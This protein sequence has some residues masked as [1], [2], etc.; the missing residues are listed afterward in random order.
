[1]KITKKGKNLMNSWESFEKLPKMEFSLLWVI[2]CVKYFL[3]FKNMKTQK[4]ETQ[5]YRLKFISKK[6]QN[7]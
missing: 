4:R 2:E 5:K 6:G 3:Q 7:E 1:M